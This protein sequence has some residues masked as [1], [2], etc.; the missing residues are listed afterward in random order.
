M[1][2]GPLKVYSCT[3]HQDNGSASLRSCCLLWLH[4]VKS[5]ICSAG[6]ESDN[7]KASSNFCSLRL[8]LL[9]LLVRPYVVWPGMLSLWGGSSR[10]LSAVMFQWLVHVK[11]TSTWKQGSKDSQ[12]ISRWSLLFISP[13]SG[14]NVVADWSFDCSACV[15]NRFNSFRC[16]YSDK[17]GNAIKLWPCLGPEW[18]PRRNKPPMN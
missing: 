12:Q 8:V 16:V 2:R 1:D 10:H 5:R 9:A 7:L 4:S 15:T 3:W 17:S 6:P 18:L 14:S 11:I 13:V